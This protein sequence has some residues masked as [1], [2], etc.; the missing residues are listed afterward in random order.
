M[1]RLKHFILWLDV[2]VE[3]VPA[4]DVDEIEFVDPIVS[5]AVLVT[6]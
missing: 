1:N 4:V 3:E 6:P 5:V 2:P